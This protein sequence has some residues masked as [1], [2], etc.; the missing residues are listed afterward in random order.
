MPSGI[1]IK[2]KNN[3]KIDSWKDGISKLSDDLRNKIIKRFPLKD[4][5]NKKIKPN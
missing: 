1:N 5:L 2:V 4:D 3:Q